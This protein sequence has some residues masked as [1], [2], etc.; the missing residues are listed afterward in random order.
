MNTS[1]H[2]KISIV[3][4]VYNAELFLMEAVSSLLNQTYNNIE[5]ICIDDASTDGSYELLKNI[6]DPCF[7]LFKND[8][9]KGLVFTRTKGYSLC[10]GDFVA[11]MDADDISSPTRLSTQLKFFLDNPQIDVVG[12]FVKTIDEKGMHI[13]EWSPPKEH[14][15][16]CASLLFEA[17]MANPTIMFRVKVLEKQGYLDPKCV[18]VEDYEMFSRL[19]LHGY[20]FANI[21]QYLLNYRIVSSGMTGTYEGKKDM[22]DAVH[23]IVYKRNFEFL[24]LEGVDLDLHRNLVTGEIISKSQ[25]ELLYR[26]LIYLVD[27]VSD[28][29]CLKGAFAQKASMIWAY[30]CLRAS[31]NIRISPFKAFY[32][33]ILCLNYYTI[34]NLSK[35]VLRSYLKRV[36]NA[37]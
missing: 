13:G 31:S 15:L 17:A 30:C 28:D 11:H 27:N 18:S 32:R 33:T 2:L 23:K 20:K 16:I 25:L 10:T 21:D 4:P 5:I 6:D 22:R 3:L 36:N 35:A 24:G 29:Y 1:E 34:K 37:K 14:N 7:K 19:A 8:L 12:T 26:H 9:N